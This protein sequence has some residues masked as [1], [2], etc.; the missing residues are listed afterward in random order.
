[1]KLI[2]QLDDLGF[3]EAVNYGI[4]KVVHEGVASA[5]GLMS[6]MPYA[7]HGYDLIK[8]SSKVVIGLHTNICTGQP[9]SDPQSIP[10][11]CDPQTGEFYTSNDIRQRAED[12]VDFKEAC[13]EVEGQVLRFK[14]IAGVYPVYIDGHAVK[15]QQLFAA[16]KTVAKQYGI[17]LSMPLFPEWQKVS[18][19]TSAKWFELDEKGVYDPIEYLVKDKGEILDKEVA[20]VIFHPGFLDHFILTNSSFTTIRTLEANALCSPQVKEWLAT[21]KIELCHF[22]NYL[23]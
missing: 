17:F 13:L 20:V 9:V 7:Q 4:S 16:I 6:N 18:G 1:M 3:S 21:E 10:T 22:K 8:D 11:L 19:I 5:V 15:S 2:I 12:T 23:N 14:E